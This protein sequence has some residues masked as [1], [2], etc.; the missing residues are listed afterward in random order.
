MDTKKVIQERRSVHSFD[1]NKK[2]TDAQFKQLFDLVKL[3]PSG[4]NLQPWE[5]IVVR[6]AAN[7]ERLKAVSYNQPHIADASA[8]VIVLGNKLASAHAVDNFDDWAR[9]GYFDQ[10]TADNLKKQMKDWDQRPEEEKRV[11]T[12]RSTA[13]AAMTLMIAAQDMGLATC[14]MEGFEADKVK[15]EFGIPEHYEVVM[16]IAIGYE[17]KSPLPR[18]WR[19]GYEEMVRHE[20]F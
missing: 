18:V 3:S 11:W 4:Y 14:P 10:G 15:K 20:K 9:K 17:A 13:L 7:K 19:R 2:V 1:P 6:D 8:A 16:L 5:F 12:T